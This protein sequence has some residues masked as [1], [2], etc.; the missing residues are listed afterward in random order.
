MGARVVVAVSGSLASLAALRAGAR[1]ARRAGLVLVAVIAWEPPE[2]EG[3]YAKR[4]DRAWAEQW[5]TAARESLDRAFDEAFGGVP[6]GVTVERRVVRDRPGRALC[7]LVSGADDLLVLGVRR[8]WS[9][10]SRYVHAHAGCP[11]MAVP[12]PWV[13]KHARRTLRRL[14]VADFV[15]PAMSPAEVGLDRRPG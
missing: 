8:R 2:G 1:E 15:R 11:V 13:P 9:R 5:E 12:G 6:Q 10:I 3:L 7:G 14:S 4:P